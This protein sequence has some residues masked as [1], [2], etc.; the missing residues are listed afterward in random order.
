MSRRETV[1]KAFMEQREFVDARVKHSTEL[2]R[3]GDAAITF[4]SDGEL[5][6]DIT[7][8][9]EQVNH[10]LKFGANLF[11]LDELESDE[12][13]W[14]YREKFPE[15]FNIAT[16][17]F[18]WNTLEPERGKPRFSKDS[19][20]VYRRPPIDLCME[21]CAEKGIEP[22]LHCLNYDLFTPDWLI[23][24]SNM[25][26]KRALAK[27]FREIG[28]RYSN[29]IPMV[30]VTNET[31]CP[32]HKTDF[33]FADDYVE[34]SFREA[35]KH[36]PAN[37]LIINESYLQW[38]VVNAST[39][40]NPYYQQIEKLLRGNVP[41][42]GIGM[43]FHSFFPREMEAEHTI[44]RGRYNPEH[45]F[46]TMDKFEQLN[47]PLQITEMTI[48]AYS[49]DA[50]DE[51]IQAELIERLY[52]IFFAQRNM[53][54]IIYWNV[55]DG[56]AHGTKP[57][58][59]TGGENKYHGALLRFDMSEK[60]AYKVLK[61]LI[62]DEWH[63]SLTKKAENGRL[64]FRGYHG[65]YKLT[66]HAGGKVIPVDYRLRRGMNNKIEVVI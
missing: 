11:M 13:N 31:Y 5:P 35:Q 3:K 41:V 26:V 59:M 16:L 22:K 47:L 8:E 37:E 29:L 34:W 6:E 58:D 32:P 28:E 48:P 55:I 24:A 53:E 57:G 14:I 43:Q 18:Y 19:P 54:A 63:T 10:Q 52:R 36:F 60:P 7:V 49:D 46:A 45:L 56:Y 12:K 1:F 65:D 64:T 38:D 30:E 50:E 23:G 42:H 25:E 39:S 66:V 21:Y 17:P 4:V 15:I 62:K 20:K 51:E 33:F 27:R 61:K 2:Y 9:I 40:H 44:K